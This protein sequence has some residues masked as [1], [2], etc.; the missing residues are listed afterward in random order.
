[1]IIPME[2]T[3]IYECITWELL[4]GV[5]Q[6][7]AGSRE[8]VSLVENNRTKFRHYEINVNRESC[9]FYRSERGK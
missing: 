2:G 5:V 4:L 7:L 1:M 8:P 6:R 3:Y 9:R